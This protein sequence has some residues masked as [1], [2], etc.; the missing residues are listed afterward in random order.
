MGRRSL[1]CKIVSV[2]RAVWPRPPEPL[3]AR[4]PPPR[5]RRAPEAL[6]IGCVLK[7]S[8]SEALA[9]IRQDG[10]ATFQRVFVVVQLKQVVFVIGTKSNG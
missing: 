10:V 1:E 3:G 6:G 8:R 4:A 2:D 5:N 9:S 7:Y